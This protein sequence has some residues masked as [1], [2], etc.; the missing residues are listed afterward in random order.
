MFNTFD[1]NRGASTD[2]QYD[3]YLHLSYNNGRRG[4]STV[5]GRG[6]AEGEGRFQR[7]RQREVTGYFSLDFDTSDASFRLRGVPHRKKQTHDGGWL[8]TMAVKTMTMTKKKEIERERER[9]RERD[10]C[11]PTQTAFRFFVSKEQT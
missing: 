4:E 6:G 10:T 11:Y 2:T 3:A 8:I 1:L 7:K 9:E 5:R